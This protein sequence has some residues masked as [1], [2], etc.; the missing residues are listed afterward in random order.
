MLN[1][2]VFFCERTLQQHIIHCSSINSIWYPARHISIL[3][4]FGHF[5]IEE[6][7][8]YTLGVHFRVNL[9]CY[10]VLLVHLR[11]QPF[12]GSVIVSR[13]RDLL[14]MYIIHAGK[15]IHSSLVYSKGQNT[16]TQS[17]KSCKQTTRMKQA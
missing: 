9:K 4:K 16:Y 14:E 11:S 13:I 10:F 17:C 15:M 2:A 3:S 7:S 6:R 5:H 8:S 1:L 12:I